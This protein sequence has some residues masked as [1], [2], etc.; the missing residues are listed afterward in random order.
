[1][2]GNNVF[3]FG[4]GHVTDDSEMAMSIAFAIMDSPNITTLNQNLLFYYYGIW[5]NTNPPGL[6][7]A[8]K[9]ALNNF[10]EETCPINKENLFDIVRDKIKKSNTPSLANGFLMRKAPLVVWFYYIN[11]DE[12][13]KTLTKE[14]TKEK[15]IKFYL[16]LKEESFKDSEITHPNEETATVGGIY[17]F[18]A[19]CAMIKLPAKEILRKLE[20]LLSLDIFNNNNDYPHEYKLKQKITLLLN[21]FSS[22]DF[23][24]ETY[25][26]PMSEEH[27]GF[28]WYAFSLTLYFLNKL[29]TIPQSRKITKYRYIMNEICNIGGDTD[30]NCA[31]VGCVIGPLL[32]YINFG[33]DFNIFLNAVSEER[34]MYSSSMM[35]YFVR[36]L[37]ETKSNSNQIESEIRYNYYKMLLNLLNNT[38][39]L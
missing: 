2:K 10:N 39:K 28:Y 22:K 26:Q 1:M 20:Y 21:D 5:R 8:T 30:T 3:D 6:G 37:E 18:L 38:I 24:Y 34:F 32:G 17:V 14:E 9:Y 33:S 31:I 13:I 4:P 36:F 16:H 7:Q 15:Y 27:I 19:L 12:I 25:T 23:N 35:F 29:D 11:K